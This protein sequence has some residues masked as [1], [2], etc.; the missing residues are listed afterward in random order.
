MPLDPLPGK[1]VLP[2]RNAERDRWLRD[3][4]LRSPDSDVSEGT[5]PWFEASAYADATAVHR[6]NAVTIANGVSRATAV[7]QDLDDW[8][9]RLGTQRL[10]A[11]G[12]G[13]FVVASVTGGGSVPIQTGQILTGP[14]SSR[15]QCTETAL[16]SDG[17]SVP[18]L[19]IT[20]GPGTNLAAGTVLT[21]QSPPIGL[22][23]TATVLQ[24]AD[25]SGLSGGNGIE[26]DD[27]LRAR[28]DY[29]AANPPASGNDAQ[30]QSIV[31]KT[32]GL[33]VQQPF[34]IPAVKGPGTK[35]VTFTLRPSQPGANRIPTSAQLSLCAAYLAGLMPA[36]D[37]I[38]MC[39][40]V[41]SPLI[42]TLKV[43][44]AQGASGWADATTFP[45][46][47]AYNSTPGDRLV[48][49]SANAS[50][51]LS[52]TAFRL[53]S[54]S[55]TEVPQ[56][57]Q[58]IAFLDL[59]NLTF[60]R[61]KIGAVTQINSTTYDITV[62]TSSGVSDTSYTPSNGQVCSPWSDSLNALLTP[63]LAYFD[64]LGPGEQ[65]AS[66]FD[67]GLRQ[68]RSPASPAYWPNIVTN[69]L[70]GGAAVPQPPQG[71]QQNQPP[72]ATL[73]STPALYDVELVEPAPPYSTP[74]GSPGVSS[75]LL[76]LGGLAVF[77]E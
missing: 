74:V 22:G 66:F 24:Q 25:G 45:L 43:L 23:E 8:A 33:A 39:T 35:G 6:A 41:A 72:V 10:P 48:A 69:R 57:G 4:S 58:N 64:T 30:Y 63:V 34:T 61:K 2:A 21:W 16:Y 49:A 12:A 67:P 1:L 70:L 5:L 60:R 9:V 7:G 32:P 76:T 17:A 50:G 11:V 77:P 71:P 47:H 14:N 42:V 54:A 75:Y 62:D 27:Q 73:F 56:V 52:P 44:W 13:G 37:S 26:S 31:G 65:F 28:L 19:G 29:I 46:Y 40:L 36:D 3:F 51:T 68:K 53:S 55:M 18:V 59:P 38:F 20:T 15:F